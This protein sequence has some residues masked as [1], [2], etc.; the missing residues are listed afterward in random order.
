MKIK[1]IGKKHW[2]GTSKKTGNDY[3]FSAVYFIGSD[4]GVIGQCGLDVSVDPSIC[5]FNEIEIGGVYDVEYGPRGRVVG[6]T[7]VK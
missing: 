3:D 1:V 7:P 4:D 2:K 6:F 5:G